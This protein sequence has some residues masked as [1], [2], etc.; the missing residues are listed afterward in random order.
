MLQHLQVHGRP[1]SFH[2]VLGH[3][4]VLLAVEDHAHRCAREINQPMSMDQL[5]DETREL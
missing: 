4:E 5:L 1:P 2:S 3:R